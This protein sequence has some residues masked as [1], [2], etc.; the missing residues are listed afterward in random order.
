M[1]TFL[2]RAFTIVLYVKWK[3]WPS[4]V[5]ITGFLLP[6]IKERNDDENQFSKTVWVIN[7]LSDPSYVAPI[8]P[9]TVHNPHKC[10][11][12]NRNRGGRYSLAADPA[13]KIVY[14]ASS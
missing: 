14:I 4:N 12:L 11:P 10:F 5:K 7:I 9:K 2:W 6:T 1:T 3:T 8:D 13:T